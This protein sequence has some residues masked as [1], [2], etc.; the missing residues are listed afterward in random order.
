MNWKI[1][2]PLESHLPS[3]LTDKSG[4][5]QGEKVKNNTPYC[6]RESVIGLKPH[7]AF[8]EREGTGTPGKESVFLLAKH[9]GSACHSDRASFACLARR[10]MGTSL[11]SH[12]LQ[13]NLNK[14][15]FPGK[16][17]KWGLV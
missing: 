7:F 4:L 3:F 12:P 14:G 1:C 11:K 5:S 10:L 15:E 13:R 17:T 9:A 6:E 8:L 2:L 16:K